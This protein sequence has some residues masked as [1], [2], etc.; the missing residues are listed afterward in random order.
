MKQQTCLHKRSTSTTKLLA[1]QKLHLQILFKVIIHLKTINITI[2]LWILWS[3]R[4][5][6]HL[7][8]HEGLTGKMERSIT[9]EKRSAKAAPYVEDESSVERR[10]RE[11]RG[12]SLSWSVLE[13]GWQAQQQP[14]FL[15]QSGKPVAIN[16]RERTRL[17]CGPFQRFLPAIPVSACLS[18]FSPSTAGTL[19][20][21][22][23]RVNVDRRNKSRA[24]AKTVLFCNKFATGSLIARWNNLLFVLFSLFLSVLYSIKFPPRWISSKFLTIYRLYRRMVKYWLEVAL[25]VRIFFIKISFKRCYRR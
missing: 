4:I 16:S 7:P 1:N 8:K 11:E 21:D 10:R 14:T 3:R 24:T 18:T 5:G 20:L 17:S 13:A 9:P 15:R 23:R 12:G 2:I 25:R 22:P 19:F 6:F